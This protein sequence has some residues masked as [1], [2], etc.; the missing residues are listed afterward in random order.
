[1]ENFWETS[2]YYTENYVEE[3]LTDEMIT[4]SEKELNCKLRIP[5]GRS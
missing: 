2:K 4:F 3:S 5:S 1:M